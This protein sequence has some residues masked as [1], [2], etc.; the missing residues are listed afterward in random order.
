MLRV[1]LS[2]VR[3]AIR[4][5]EAAEC[6][7]VIKDSVYRNLGDSILL[8]GGLDTS[9]IAHVAA[10]QTR[11]KCFTVLFSLAGAP[12]VYY[13]RLIA[14]RLGL[15][16]EVLELTPD[17]LA[18]RLTDVIRV[19][20]TFDP[21]EVR[22]SVTVYHGLMAARDQGFSKVMTGDAADELFAG[23]SFSFNLPPAELLK[24]LRDLWNVMNFSSRPMANDLGISAALPYLDESVVMFA[25]TLKPSQLVGLRN[26]KK[27]GKLILRVAF[28]E[29][30]GKR[31][32]W[33]VKTP[34]EFGSGTTVLPQYY[35]SR[36]SDDMFGR[37][38]KEAASR[39]GVKIR[40][41]EHLEYYRLFRTIYPAPS[42]MAATDNR[43]P[44][45]RADVRQDSTFCVT[46]G[47]YPIAAVAAR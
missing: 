36:T 22:N 3:R 31:S 38:V 1:P 43:C 37:S 33:R 32:A 5:D 6:R 4:A 20:K 16:L 9:I 30:I 46:C 14:R 23:Y 18:V 13:A 17:L 19:L 24:R 41:K 8:S 39:D 12:D 15:D 42:E 25:K 7:E 27:Y 40:D 28:E 2:P 44:C 26:K 34:V 10:K 29:S 35:A 47:A 45:C 21:M 11:P